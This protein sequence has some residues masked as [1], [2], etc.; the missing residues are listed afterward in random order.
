MRTRLG[1]KKQPPG[2]VL[3]TLFDKDG[4]PV[5]D[6]EGKPVTRTRPNRAMSR[7]VRSF[8]KRYVKKLNRQN[9]IEMGILNHG[10]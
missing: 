10:K 2:W 4:K 8:E 7:R 9:R 6:S 1:G 5:L 3:E